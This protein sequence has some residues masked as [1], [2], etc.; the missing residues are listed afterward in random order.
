MKYAARAINK[1]ASYPLPMPLPIEWYDNAIGREGQAVMQEY[2]KL[3]EDY[4]LPISREFIPVVR[5]HR[6]KEMWKNETAFYSSVTQIAMH[7]AYQQIIGMGVTAISF[8]LRE[9]AAKPDQWFW[10][11]KSI[12]GE[13]PVSPECRGNVKEMSKA[14][15]K[16]GRE[17][18]YIS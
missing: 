1:Q 6:L 14:W 17:R 8:I 11:L 5:F 16:W 18:G 12:T 13:D 4:F 3:L 15:L 2:E 10:A 9:M 7:P